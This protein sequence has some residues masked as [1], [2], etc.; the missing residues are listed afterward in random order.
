MHDVT[1]LH[2]PR[3]GVT[4]RSATGSLNPDGGGTHPTKRGRTKRAKKKKLVMKKR[5]RRKSG[6]RVP[7]S[8]PV[9]A[10]SVAK[11]QEYYAKKDDGR[12]VC[13]EDGHSSE[14][15]VWRREALERLARDLGTRASIERDE[16]GMEECRIRWGSYN[17]L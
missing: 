4:A 15:R 9:L 12:R 10:R 6:W 11:H 1:T 14:E 2:T 13:A 16:R 3:R 8:M 7:E 17:I 5:R